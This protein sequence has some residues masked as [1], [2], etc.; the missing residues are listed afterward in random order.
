MTILIHQPN[1]KLFKHAMEDRRVAQEFF[2]THIPAFILRKIDLKS[3]QLEKNS[4]IDELYKHCEADIVYSAKIGKNR[5]YFYILC[6]HQSKIDKHIAFRLLGYMMRVM[7]NHRKQYPK[8]ALPVIYPLVLYT[9]EQEWNAPREIFDLFGDQKELMRDIFMKPYSLIEVRKEKDEDL[10]HRLWSGMVEFALKHQRSSDFEK[11]LEIFLPW[12]NEI[13]NQE[14]ANYAQIV[15]RYVIHDLDKGHEQ[16]FIEKSNE[17]LS[18]K[19]RGEV[20]TIAQQIE[21]RG[22]QQ[23]MQQGMRQGIQ[24]GLLE[25]ELTMLI[26]LL[27]RKFG[28][29]PV[30]YKSRLQKADSI[31]LLQWAERI[32][33]AK[34]I[35][36][37]FQEV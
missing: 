13:D 2:E 4:F 37:I 25:G 5:G 6:E 36:E 29:I 10:R 1:D 27:N 8:E 23:G 15:L 17:Y 33:E 21:Q 35:Q 31:M 9:G 24:Q 30:Q 20:M 7:E 34:T 18:Q 32:I 16:L 22:M 19:L 12:V 3:L 14:G 26:N 28:R 11:F